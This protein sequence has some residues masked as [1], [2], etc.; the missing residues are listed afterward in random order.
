MAQE[1]GILL[2]GKRGV[3]LLTASGDDLTA[4]G[5]PT[6]KMMRQIAGAFAE[7]E[8]ARLVAKLRSGRERKRRETGRKVGGPKSHAE[9]HPE[10]VR[11]AKR[12]HRAN[13]VTGKHR[14]LRKIAYE[15]A[16]MGH[17]N[18]DGWPFNPSSIRSMLNA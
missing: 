7:Y 5:D 13:P 2:L 3:R 18:D 17:V 6:R 11:E 16:R 8:K 9:L 1:L 4:T 12:L 14:S 15:L 10:V